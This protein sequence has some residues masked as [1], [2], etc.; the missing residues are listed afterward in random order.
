[1]TEKTKYSYWFYAAV[2]AGSVGFLGGLYYL[3]TLMKGEPELNEFDKDVIEKIKVDL[4][5]KNSGKLTTENAIKILAMINKKTE[6]HIRLIKPEIEKKRREALNRPEEYE[7]ICSE[8][9]QTRNEVYM[10]VSEKIL[11]EFGY[12]NEEIGNCLQTL[13]PVEIE[14]QM[15]ASEKPE[16]PD[17][18]ITKE[19]AKIAFLFYGN[20]CVSQMSN[21]QKMMHS[22]TNDQYQQEFMLYQLMIMKFKIDDELHAKY[23]VGENQLRYLLYEYDLFSDPQIKQLVTKMA[24]LEDFMGGAMNMQ[25]N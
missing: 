11:N 20:K 6:E 14:K 25:Q 21:F 17:G 13:S 24:S 12:S 4:D 2:A 1:M 15:L 16:F 22:A 10:S 3:Y 18:Q 8:I 19:E 7:Q 5:E 9:L 23:K